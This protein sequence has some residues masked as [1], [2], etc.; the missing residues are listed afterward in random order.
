MI[1]YLSAVLKKYVFFNLELNTLFMM[2][3]GNM[4]MM[5]NIVKKVSNR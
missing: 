4:W 3:T 5:I 2:M 1:K